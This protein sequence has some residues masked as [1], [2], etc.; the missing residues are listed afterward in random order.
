VRALG[1]IRVEGLANLPREG[2]VILAVNHQSMMDGP[3]LFGFIDRPVACLVKREAFVPVLGRVLLDAGQIPIERGAI[4]ARPVR[5]GLQI[6]KA[7]GVL[8]V[9][10][11]G[12]RGDGLVRQAKP[13]VGYFALRTGATV[14]PV[15]CHGTADLLGTFRRRPVR[16]DIGAPMTF[17]AQPE[18]RP[19]NRRLSAAATEQVRLELAALVTRANI[20]SRGAIA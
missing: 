12:S 19:L 14:V 10:P 16:I 15:A 9:F 6:L 3:L 11:E 18:G 13:G 4:D 7:G 20:I 2:P 8:G 5:L 17:A 1:E